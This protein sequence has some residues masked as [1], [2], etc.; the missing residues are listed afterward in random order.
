MNDPDVPAVPLYQ[1]KGEDKPLASMNDA[2]FEAWFNRTKTLYPGDWLWFRDAADFCDFYGA[3]C[4]PPEAC[5][6][7]APRR[8]ERHVTERV[9]QGAQHS[10]G[11]K[12]GNCNPHCDCKRTGV[13]NPK[14]ERTA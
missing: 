6:G 3:Q 13:A 5:V 8:G 9:S 2:E 4:P 12:E 14:G 7:R 11:T 1:E 10:A